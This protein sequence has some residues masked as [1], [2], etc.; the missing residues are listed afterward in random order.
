MPS[1]EEVDVVMRKFINDN[2]Q[3]QSE[4]EH[5]NILINRKNVLSSTLAAIQRITFSFVKLVHVSFSGE[6]DVDAGGPRRE[7]F[8]LLMS[9]LKNLGIF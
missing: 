3:H 4:E 2:L 5:C 6:E 8:R 9:S 1:S 7:Y